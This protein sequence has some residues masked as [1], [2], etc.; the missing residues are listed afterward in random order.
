MINVKETNDQMAKN[1]KQLL[2]LYDLQGF[3]TEIDKI[4]ILR[5]EYPLDIQD[6]KDEIE[7]TEVR[8]KTHEKEIKQHQKYISSRKIE[9]EEKERVIEHLKNHLRQCKD[10]MQ[11]NCLNNEI[12][13]KTKEI[14]DCI[15]NIQ[16]STNR[17]KELKEHIV[18]IDEQLVKMNEELSLMEESYD[19]VIVDTKK[20]EDA[21]IEKCKHIEESIEPRLLKGFQ[22]LRRACRNGLAVVE[23]QRE[24]CGGCFNRIP[25][26]QLMDI[27]LHRKLMVCE[28]CGRI[29]IDPDLVK[30]HPNSDIEPTKEAG[31]S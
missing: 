18:K 26:Q 13:Y 17:L 2:L 15:Q 30:D 19:E 4:K 21:L 7:G 25:P 31:I 3:K 23:I 29:L 28:Y 8:R 1:L 9:I 24:A 11:V 16:K 12:K 27:R 5:C 14:E 22:R 10:N 20:Q 6:L